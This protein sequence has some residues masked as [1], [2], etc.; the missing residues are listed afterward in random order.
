MKKSI[1]LI[2]TLVLA[3][4]VVIIPQSAAYAKTKNWYGKYCEYKETAKKAVKIK[5]SKVYLKGK[6]ENKEKRYD[7]VKEKKIKKTF[8]LTGKTK[9]YIDD[10][11]SDSVKRVSLKKFKKNMYSDLCYI[12]FKVK[13][14]KVV[15]AIVSLN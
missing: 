10:T 9:Y 2:L 3:L 6:W 12:S 13:S 15:K 5:G 14:K 11:A 4:S 1:A 8:K 7:D